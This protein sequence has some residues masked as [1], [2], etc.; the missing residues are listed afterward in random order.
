MRLDEATAWDRFRAARVA[1]LATAGADGRP[2]LVPVTF[3][4]D[5]DARNPVAV[6]AI[7][8]K[9]KT[10]TRLRRLRNI[11]DNP[12]VALL[13]DDY[14]EDWTQLWW[15]RLDGTAH[16]LTDEPD[17]AAPIAWLTAKYPQYQDNSPTGPVIR[18][19]VDTVSGWAYTD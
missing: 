7:D 8:H 14:S 6:I 10:T 1:R 11:A 16:I 4:T 19:V 2:H 12:R 3:A 18:I 9:P 5:P 15:V 17:R 13:A